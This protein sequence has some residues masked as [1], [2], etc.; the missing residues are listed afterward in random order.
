[1]ADMVLVTD[2]DHFGEAEIEQLMGRVGRR[3]RTSDAVLLRGTTGSPIGAGI[4]VK[5]N[6]RVRKGKVVHTFQLQG[7]GRRNP[8]RRR[9]V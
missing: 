9:I 6:T 7:S 3:E 8:N 2:A 4:K 5:A 1:M